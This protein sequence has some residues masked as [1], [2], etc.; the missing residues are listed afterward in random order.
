MCQFFVERPLAVQDDENA[1][2]DWEQIV[3]FPSSYSHYA[4]LIEVGAPVWLRIEKLGDEGQGIMLPKPDNRETLV[5]L[6]EEGRVNA[7]AEGKLGERYHE[8]PADISVYE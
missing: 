6:D 7:K 4:K 1:S 5:R 3:A 2:M 8:A